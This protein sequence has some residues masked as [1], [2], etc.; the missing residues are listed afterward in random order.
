MIGIVCGLQSEARMVQRV[1]RRAAT[2][3]VS[4]ASAERARSESERLVAEGATIL[5]SI[6]VAGGLAPDLRAGRLVI[7]SRVVCPDET[8]VDASPEIVTRA[9]EALWPTGRVAPI[10]G[11]DALISTPQAKAELRRRTQAAAVDM[12]S[13]AVAL[14]AAEKEIAFAALRAVADAAQSALPAAAEDSVDEEGRP[15][16]REVM[17]SITR[18]PTDLPRLIGLASASASAHAA[19]RRGLLRL[20]A[21]GVFAS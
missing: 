16:V 6:G 3:A 12:E 18:R 2:I 11:S 20:N 17:G 15:R 14:V 1:V 13:H 9:G 8:I 4:G 10:A 19:L 5:W 7:A 21:A